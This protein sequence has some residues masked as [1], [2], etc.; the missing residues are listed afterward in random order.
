MA[1]ESGASAARDLRYCYHKESYLYDAHGFRVQSTSPAGR[2]F[3]VYGQS[4]ELVFQRDERTGTNKAY[5]HLAGSLVA[6]REQPLSDGA[7]TLKYHHTD[8]LGSPVLVTGLG[9]E[10]LE[11]TEYEPYGRVLNRARTNTPGF[12][13]HVEDADT[14]LTYM[15]QR[16]FDPVIGGFLSVDPVT[17]Y[18][19]GD[20]RYLTRYAYAY[21]NPYRFTD[22]DGRLAIQ[23]A[24]GV[25]GALISGGASFLKGNDSGTIFRDAMVGGAVGMLSTIPGGGAIAA[26]VRAGLAS[27]GGDAFTQAMDKGVANVDLKQSAKE[28]VVGGLTGGVAKGSVDKLIPNRGIPGLPSSHPLVREGRAIAQAGSEA[29]D[30]AVRDAA[31]VAG[32]AVIGGSVAGTRAALSDES[33]PSVKKD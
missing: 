16:Y 17:A 31:E 29:R 6:T 14:G 18:S 32:G 1:P 2:I 8:A 33:P 19:N 10:V 13:G 11:R 20:W 26:G 12:T 28:V 27:G 25:A 22:P 15:Q 24:G 7:P 23:I 30:S 3:S 9:R 5:V 4:G 21:N